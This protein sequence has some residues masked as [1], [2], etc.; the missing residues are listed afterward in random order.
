MSASGVTIEGLK[1][2]PAGE[3]APRKVSYAKKKPFVRGGAKV[4][5]VKVEEP[6]VVEVPEVVEVEKAEEDD[7]KE[8]WEMSDEEEVEVKK[9]ESVKDDWDA[10]DSE[11]EE[12]KVVV[13]KK[14]EK[15]VP[16]VVAKGECILVNICGKELTKRFLRQLYPLQPNLT[17]N[18]LLPKTPRK[19]PLP[20]LLRL[21]RQQLPPRS[22]FPLAFSKPPSNPLYKER[23]LL[24]LDPSLLSNPHPK[25][26]RLQ[27]AP[28]Q[29]L[30]QTIQI[31]TLTIVT[32]IVKT[33]RRLKGMLWLVKQHRSERRRRRD[34][35]QRRRRRLRLGV[36]TT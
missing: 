30:A 25:K 7:V 5:E 24:H 26:N 31:L 22:L 21:R 27:R 16:A 10:S 14:V 11:E 3:E 17:A 35:W 33:K 23:S 34:G 1:T 9:A 8:D 13:E 6:V 19:L 18:L 2:P 28:L 20:R 15:V 4:A 12:E 36:R 29:A 32:M